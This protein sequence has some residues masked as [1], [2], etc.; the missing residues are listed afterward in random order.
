[1][2]TMFLA[3]ALLFQGPVKDL[4]VP[5]QVKPPIVVPAGTTIPVSLISRVST[6]NA[7]PGDGVYARTLFPVTVGNEIV[8]PVGSHVRG[9]ISEVEQPGRIKGKAVLTLSFQQIILPSGLTL[10]LF[11]TLAGTGG[12]GTRTGETSIEGE[13]TKGEDAKDIGQATATGAA[14][15]AIGGRGKG[16]GIGAG[17]GAAA[18][19]VGV[20]LAR[21][22]DLVLEPGTT[23]EI[24]LDRPLEP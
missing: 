3:L 15:G 10:P 14:I 16:L 20:L 9:K 13:S 7:K 4:K 6:K 2:N 1:M 22:K 11:A 12:A 18:G 19:A 23:I 5:D 17:V 8:I 24:V 21:G